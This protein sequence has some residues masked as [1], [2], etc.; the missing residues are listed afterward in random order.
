[1]TLLFED[2]A[3][4]QRLPTL[5]VD[6]T[7]TLVVLGAMASRD[8]R[9]MHHDHAFA[10]ERQGLKDIFL[11]TPNQAAWFERYI[12]DWTGPYGRLGRMTFRM[13][14]S[15]FPG[16][17]MTIDGTVTALDVDGTGCGWVGLALDLRV[18]DDSRTSCTARVALPTAPD[19]NP[20]AR[21]GARWAP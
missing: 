9:P 6:V 3:E 11:N 17:P 15:V 12:T 21:R 16:D 20:W 2:I 13:K 5:C 18:G 19:D 10:V 14:G 1:M 7:A 8:W 4:G